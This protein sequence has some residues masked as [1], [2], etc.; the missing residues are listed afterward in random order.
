M[1]RNFNEVRLYF[2]LITSFNELKKKWIKDFTFLLL[3][4]IIY[5]LSI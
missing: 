3:N 1:Y 4:T 5:Y 2:D